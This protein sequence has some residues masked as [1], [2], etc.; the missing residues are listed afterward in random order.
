MSSDRSNRSGQIERCRGRRVLNFRREACRNS[1]RRDACIQKE[2]ERARAPARKR[3]SHCP[4][5][6]PSCVPFLSSHDDCKSD[7]TDATEDHRTEV[8]PT[9]RTRYSRIRRY[10]VRR[11]V[12]DAL[13]WC[14]N[15][16][17]EDINYSIRRYALLR[18][19]RKTVVLVHRVGTSRS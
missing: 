10:S 7:A 2:R 8:F 3:G 6:F 18:T 5:R 1:T 19:T 15:I 14:I 16:N 12:G 4:F 13:P 11:T 17:K 9:I